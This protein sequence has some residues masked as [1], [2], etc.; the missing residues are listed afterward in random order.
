MLFEIV[1]AIFKRNV[2]LYFQ[3]LAFFLVSSISFIV[4]MFFF[5]FVFFLLICQR[6]QPENPSCS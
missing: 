2:Y 4:F 3:L 5:L 1:V 6:F